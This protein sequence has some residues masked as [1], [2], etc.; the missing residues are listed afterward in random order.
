MQG[1]I[2]A[3]KLSLQGGEFKFNVANIK[4]IFDTR[5]SNNLS[6]GYSNIHID[7]LIYQEPKQTLFKLVNLNIKS[8]LTNDK[9]EQ[10]KLQYTITVNTESSKILKQIFTENTYMLSARA[11]N[12]EFF[13]ILHANYDKKFA[14]LDD[15]LRQLLNSQAKVELVLPKYFS[16]SLVTFG[17]FQLYKNSILG[18]IDPRPKEQILSEISNTVNTKFDN[19]V[20]NKILVDNKDSQQYQLHIEFNNAGKILL[21]G[22]PLQNP[23]QALQE[24]SSP[25]KNQQEFVEGGACSVTQPNTENKAETKTEKP[26]APTTENTAK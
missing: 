11:I 17:N 15:L 16:Q 19:L 1:E 26:I 10:Q 12:P 20:A 18:K 6:I 24:L 7:K 2:T 13:N 9:D 14:L 3:P 21:N 5:E 23:L 4:L 22:E 8:T 25:A